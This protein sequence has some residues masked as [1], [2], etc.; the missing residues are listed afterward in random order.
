MMLLR[1]EQSAN[2]TAFIRQPGVKAT[3]LLA[4]L[5]L[6]ASPALAQRQS[7][8]YNLPPGALII[9]T[10]P[11]KLNRSLILWMLNPRRIPRDVA[12]EPYTCP[13]ETRGNYYNGPTR[14]SLV[15]TRTRRII[16]TVRVRQEYN[17]G[18]DEFDIPYLIHSGSYYHVEGVPVGL[19]GKPTIMR[20]RDYNGDGLALE[21]ALF[22]AL[23]CMGLQ[24][25]LIGYSE[26][27][28]R[29]IQYKTRLVVEEKRA[30]S[31]KI[32][33]WVDYLFSGRP[34]GAGRWQYEVDYRGRGGLL[35]KYEI[36]YN[37]R[38]ER[39][40]GRVAYTEGE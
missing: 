27:R 2:G 6:F 35:A 20:L 3:A 11:I 23:A 30:R 9:E 4:C 38:A 13:E 12:E 8:E 18:V 29:V 17:E 24:T 26:R 28:D 33:R 10:Q 16:N 7:L 40:E 14:V 25:A 15:D 21:F 36:R 31:V 39:F 37:R 1:S 5:I 34:K 32:R 22:D 19:E